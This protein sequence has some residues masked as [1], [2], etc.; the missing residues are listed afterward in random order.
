MGTV[1]TIQVVAAAMRTPAHDAIERAFD[2]FREVE[3]RCTRFDPESELMR[4]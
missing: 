4:L 2:W 1:V 3:A